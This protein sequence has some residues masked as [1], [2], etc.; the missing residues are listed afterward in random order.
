M[1]SNLSGPSALF[2]ADVGRIQERIADASRQISSG[3]KIAAPS[4]A[5]DEIEPLLQL[6]ADRERNQQIQSN[7]ALAKTGADS[8]DAALTS[9]VKLMDRARTLAAQGA[10]ATLDA[11]GRR[12]L[13]GEIESL[14][15]Q[16][17][18]CSRTAVQ[19]R[20]LFSGDQDDSAAYEV[21]LTAQTGAA[22]LAA[23]AAPATRRI[24]H[25]AGGSFAASMTAQDIFD[26]RNQDGSPSTENVFAALNNLRL[27]LLDGDPAAV[28]AAVPGLQDAAAQLNAAQAFY[29]A[30]QGRIQDAQSYSDS[31]DVHLQVQLSQ[32]EDADATAAALELTQSNTQLQ[33]AFQ[34]RAQLPTQS[35]FDY[36]G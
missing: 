17:V 36:L 28:D 27:A 2:L 3:K 23:A 4:D 19:G 15:E 33:A 1:L 25:P 6:R 20:F 8:A 32:K 26:K 31:Y 29:G 5:P 35:L 21:D 34:M 24:E 13:A 18:V 16:M 7:L 14:Q 11:A 30:V 9:A 12:S 22:Q 10:T